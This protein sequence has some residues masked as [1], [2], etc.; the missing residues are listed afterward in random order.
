MILVRSLYPIPHAPTPHPQAL[1][2]RAQLK[3]LMSLHLDME[4][5]GGDLTAGEV[6]VISGALDLAAKEAKE[7]MTSIDKARRAR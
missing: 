6:N 2:R 7:G 5:F 4:G 1:L 3:A